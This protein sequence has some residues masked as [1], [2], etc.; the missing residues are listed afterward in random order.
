MG[1]QLLHQCFSTYKFAQKTCVHHTHNLLGTQHEL[2][3]AL[4]MHA[5]VL[6]ERL[7][8][9][10][11]SKTATSAVYNLVHKWLQVDR[12]SGP[13]GIVI[14]MTK[15][16]DD[17]RINYFCNTEGIQRLSSIRMVP[18]CQRAVVLRTSDEAPTL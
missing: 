16:S 9:R 10:L 5:T 17:F 3:N 14:L 18:C 4:C 8:N 1:I 11:M 2:H 12:L 7:H 13:H 6:F 15:D